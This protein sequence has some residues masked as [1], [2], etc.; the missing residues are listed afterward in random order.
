MNGKSMVVVGTVAAA[1]GVRGWVKVT[2][3]TD[4]PGRF[5]ALKSVFLS[6]SGQAPLSTAILEVAFQPK[7]VL[8]KF[9]GTDSR[10]AAEALRGAELLIPESEVPP[11]AEGQYY[12]YQLEGLRVE[13]DTGELIGTLEFVGKTGG[14]DVY[15]VLPPGGGSHKLVPAV[16]Q[17]I[18]SIDLERGIMVVYKD[19]VV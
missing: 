14:N 18:K 8:L 15:F 17:G 2:P 9:Q 10:E 3:L 6:V 13:T 19:W 1:H 12:Y 4:D 11:P 7:F 16:K 5:S